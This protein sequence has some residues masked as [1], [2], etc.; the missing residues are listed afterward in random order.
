MDKIVIFNTALENARKNLVT[1]KTDLAK[2][3]VGNSFISWRKCGNIYGR[4]S[5][6]NVGKLL[7]KKKKRAIRAELNKILTKG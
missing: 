6:G 3:W 2:N 5:K 7:F 1:C 4:F